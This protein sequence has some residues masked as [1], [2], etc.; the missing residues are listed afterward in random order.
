MEDKHAL[1]EG[2]YAL[3][4]LI[5]DRLE[6]ESTD[7][8]DYSGLLTL[9]NATLDRADVLQDVPE[10]DEAARTRALVSLAVGAPQFGLEWQANCDAP[11]AHDLLEGGSRA[12]A[13]LM[14][15]VP[16]EDAGS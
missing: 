13:A 7:Q 1:T 15:H 11:L 3:L 4:S 5:H 16:G 8:V 14:G 2:A 9:I 10:L 12:L 6:R